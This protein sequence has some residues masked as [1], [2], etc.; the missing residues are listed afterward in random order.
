MSSP[1]A[2]RGPRL[3]TGQTTLWR[4]PVT[5]TGVDHWHVPAERR[6]P[7]AGTAASDGCMVAC[8]RWGSGLAASPRATEPG[9]GLR[10]RRGGRAQTPCSSG[11]RIGQTRLAWGTDRRGSGK[12]RGGGGRV[13]PPRP[14]RSSAGGRPPPRSSTRSG[15]PS[16]RPVREASVGKGVESDDAAGGDNGEQD[17]G[18]EV[19]GVGPQVVPGVP[20]HDPDGGD[21]EK[22]TD[23]RYPGREPD[24]QRNPRASSAMV[25]KMLKN[26]QWGMTV[27]R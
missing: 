10:N 19:C 23:R 12:P 25:K 20:Q 2:S 8:R 17:Q 7:T 26:D 22:T 3:R 1:D 9:G 27:S 11:G 6:R 13:R 24:D 5:A 14:A 21:Q 4:N 18:G 16:E 15:L